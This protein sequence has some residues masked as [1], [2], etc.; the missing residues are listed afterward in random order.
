MKKKH[1]EFIEKLSMRIISLIL[2]VFHFSLSFVAF[3]RDKNKTRGKYY[4]IEGR[5]IFHEMG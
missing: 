3:V 5:V 2:L 4:F 1:L